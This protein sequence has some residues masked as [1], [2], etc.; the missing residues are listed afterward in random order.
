MCKNFKITLLQ[1]EPCAVGSTGIPGLQS[2][3]PSH[4]S[5]CGDFVTCLYRVYTKK[6][7]ELQRA[8][9]RESLG[10]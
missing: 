2:T 1:K 8:I 7:I 4:D 9:I 6:V 5:Y 10:V 3:L